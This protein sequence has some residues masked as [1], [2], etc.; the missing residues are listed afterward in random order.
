MDKCI[1]PNDD[2]MG[3]ALMDYQK[4]IRDTELIVGTSVAEDEP[5]D[6]SYFFRNFDEMPEL[7]Q[8]ALQLAHGAILDVGAGTGIHSLALEEMEKSCVSIDISE[9]SV[10]VMNMRGVKN[11]RCNDFYK[12]EDQKYDTLLFLM[13]GIGLVETLEGFERFFKKCKSLL[14]PG[15]QILFDSSDLIYLF[16]EEDGTFLIELGH[17]YYGEV[18]FKIKYQDM[19]ELSFP[20]LFVDF[21]NVENLAEQNG[22]QAE[23]IQKGEHYDYLARLTLKL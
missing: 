15:G 17:K 7:E 21:D 1:K 9:L 20:W 16:E 2:A 18:D 23:I 14:K 22:F 13:N 5:Y 12:L 10:E 19:K 6:V 4:G 3:Q 11:A 8:K